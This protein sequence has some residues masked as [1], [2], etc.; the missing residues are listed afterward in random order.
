MALSHT[1]FAQPLAMFPS[2]GAG[3]ANALAV[4]S[5]TQP[6]TLA[7]QPASC[8]CQ[9]AN[10]CACATPATSGLPSAQVALAQAGLGTLHTPP[11]LV[12]Q[13][14]SIGGFPLL[15]YQ[16]GNGHQVLIEQRPSEVVSLRTFIRAGSVDEAPV[17]PSPLYPKD[18]LPS[19]IAHLDEHCHFLT[20]Q[21]FNQPNQWVDTVEHLGADLNA[22]TGY[23]EIQH[24][25]LFNHEDLPNLLQLHAEA[26]LHPSYQA[27][28][29]VQ[30]KRNVINEC[31]ER[32][33]APDAVAYSKLLE[34]MF[35]RPHF[36]SLGNRSDIIRTTAE[37]IEAY[38]QRTYTPT[39]M[40]TVISG[41][42]T[43][44]EV[45]PLLNQQ[46]GSVL[47]PVG[48]K[49]NES[50][51]KLALGQ[52]EQRSVTLQDPQLTLSQVFLG[53]AG[54]SYH[55]PKRM[56]A[57]QLLGKLLVDNPTSPI[58]K[59][60]VDETHLANAVGMDF[61][62]YKNTGLVLFSLST[63][64]GQEQ[65]ALAALKQQLQQASQ[66]PPDAD[67]LEAAKQQLLATYDKMGTSVASSSS[68]LGG[69]LLHG[70]LN[71]VLNWPNILASITPQVIQT[72]AA[73]TLTPQR[74]VT[75]F[76][77]PGTLKA[78]SPKWSSTQGEL[79]NYEPAGTLVQPLSKKEG[80]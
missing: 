46:F 62:A 19:G 13:Y 3:Q 57:L 52:N 17:Y 68:I 44:A 23:E 18:G 12:G 66:L 6:Q 32:M 69:A 72:I 41:N 8:A 2:A 14:S 30:E 77:Q 53:F 70:T 37:D 40:V 33:A 43:P 22:S 79:P 73:E 39:N 49:P 20:T 9:G 58:R 67:K 16:L 1:S 56:I 38:Y 10:P 63:N 7:P 21:H 15:H 48:D 54:P 11:Q 42:V 25:L 4:P 27:Q 80:A 47:P 28:A 45:L 59:Q 64:P 50:G 51:L 24:E 5:Q 75:V 31:S 29:I 36:Q 78:T 35:D 60:L 76:M 65:P 26:V 61:E 74:N 71:N 55:D 34:L